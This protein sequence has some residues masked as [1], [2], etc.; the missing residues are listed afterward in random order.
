MAFAACASA[1]CAA[2]PAMAIAIT[3]AGEVFPSLDLSQ[4]PRPHAGS[5]G[6]GN[7]LVAVRVQGQSPAQRL[8]LRVET[9]GLRR[10]SV[11]DAAPDALGRLELRPRLDWDLAALRSLRQPREQVLTVTLLQDERVIDTQR[12]AVRLHPLDEALYFV[13]DGTDQVDLGWAFA[14]YVDPHDAVIDQLLDRA[15]RHGV[16]LDR[17]AAD[18]NGRLRQAWALWSAL[19]EHG[20]RYA[21]D[22][23]AL[24]QGPR[25]YSQRVRLL[26]DIWATRAANCIDGSVLIASALE[27][28]GIPTFLV[29]VPGHALVGYYVD[30]ARRDAEFIETTL[31]GRQLPPP[32]ALPGYARDVDASAAGT[33]AGFE[34]ARRDGRARWRSAAGRLEGRHRPDYALIDIATARAYGIMPLAMRGAPRPGHDRVEPPTAA[35]QTRRSGPW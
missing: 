21:D 29:L 9:P 25:I 19:S 34:S 5:V 13:R 26:A 11:I 10:P 31:L 14:A 6:G 2:Q 16:P 12:I 35:A 8:Q 1:P 24:D 17:P 7:G 20:L 30:D 4:A 23:P 28:I 3:P 22:N 32:R 15:R 18:R 33:L 27:R